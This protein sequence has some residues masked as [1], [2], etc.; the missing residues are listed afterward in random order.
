MRAARV[1]E[2]PPPDPTNFRKPLPKP[3][4][5]KKKRPETA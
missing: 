3:K 5:P 1:V 2:I 4:V